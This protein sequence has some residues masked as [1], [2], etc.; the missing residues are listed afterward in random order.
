M[1]MLGY[2]FFSY[3][4]NNVTIFLEN[5]MKLEIDF[6]ES[7]Q[8]QKFIGVLKSFNNGI[9]IDNKI[10]NQIKEFFIYKW[11]ND[12]TYIVQTKDDFRIMEQLT[13]SCQSLIFKDFLYNDFLTQFR[14]LFVFKIPVSAVNKLNKKMIA[15]KYV[16]KNLEN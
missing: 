4:S 13:D 8:L 2:V 12:K 9:P 14:R 16:D 7:Q 5:Y 6:D 11:N 15:P 10:Q 3:I 1:F